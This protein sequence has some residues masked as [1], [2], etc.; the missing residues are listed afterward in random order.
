MGIISKESLK[1]VLLNIRD[2]GL[3]DITNPDVVKSYLEWNEIEKNGILLEADEIVSFSEQIL[4]RMQQCP[5]CVTAGEC[6]VV[7]CHCPTM[8][9]IRTPLAHCKAHMWGK[10]LPPDEWNAFKEDNGIQFFST[11][12]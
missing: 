3:E 11:K 1:R 6:V 8:D 2:R 7:K 5:A 12:K 10:M 9:M 4:Y